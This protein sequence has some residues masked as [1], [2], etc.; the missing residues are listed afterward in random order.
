MGR[1]FDCDAA[2]VVENLI[3]I[4]GFGDD[5]ADLVVVDF[6]STGKIDVFEPGIEEVVS[7]FFGLF[8]NNSA[9]CALGDGDCGGGGLLDAGDDAF[10]VG[11]FCD[12]FGL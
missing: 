3:A 10:F 7:C 2:A 12:F 9:V 11:G 6:C 4:A 8:L 1:G 5:L